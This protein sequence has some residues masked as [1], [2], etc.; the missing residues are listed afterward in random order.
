MV[1]K[2]LHQEN[3]EK[4]FHL[5]EILIDSKVLKI[6]TSVLNPVIVILIEIKSPINVQSLGGDEEDVIVESDHIV[7][8]WVEAEDEEEKAPDDIIDNQK[9]EK[10]VNQKTSWDNQ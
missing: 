3:L 1:N 2:F 7:N 6:L 4:K 8:H 5:L 10:E 9:K